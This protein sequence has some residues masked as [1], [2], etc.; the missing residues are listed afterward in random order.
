MVLLHCDDRQI[1]NFAPGMPEFEHLADRI[2]RHTL[3]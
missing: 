3:V 1:P 2:G